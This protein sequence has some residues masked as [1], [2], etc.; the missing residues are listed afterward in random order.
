[1]SENRQD[2]ERHCEEERRSK[3]DDEFASAYY[4]YLSYCF[5]YKDTRDTWRKLLVRFT[6]FATTRSGSPPAGSGRGSAALH[7]LL[8]FCRPYG[9]LRS[10][11]RAA[12]ILQCREPLPAATDPLRPQ[13]SPKPSPPYTR[14]LLRPILAHT[15]PNAHPI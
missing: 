1:M 10:P 13:S 2:V 7:R 5:F 15:S 8:N 6:S 3:P 4:A 11:V 12:E 9:T 14:S